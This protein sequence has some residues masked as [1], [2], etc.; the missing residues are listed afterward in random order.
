MKVLGL[1]FL[2]RVCNSDPSIRKILPVNIK[3]LCSGV[4]GAQKNFKKSIFLIFPLFGVHN[5]TYGPITIFCLLSG[6]KFKNEIF[7]TL[8]HLA[9]S[10]SIQSFWCFSWQHHWSAYEYD[11]V[12]KP[13]PY[14]TKISRHK[15]SFSQICKRITKKLA[16]S[17]HKT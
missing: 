16:G 17:Q 3:P 14:W 10:D 15:W 5:G 12:A 2:V 6:N 1:W 4:L 13:P 11:T 8:T 7:M 9:N